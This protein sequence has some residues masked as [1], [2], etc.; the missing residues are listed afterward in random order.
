MLE[1][2]RIQPHLA[3]LHPQ[4][5]LP[6]LRAEIT[7][8]ILP[9]LANNPGARLNGTEKLMDHLEEELEEELLSQIQT[10]GDTPV[11]SELPELALSSLVMNPIASWRA[12]QTHVY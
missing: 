5:P 3:P 1:L 8:I 9:S 6:S 4:M 11:Q 10:Q 2:V 7:I 12:M